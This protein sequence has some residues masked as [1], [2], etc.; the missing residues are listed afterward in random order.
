MPLIFYFSLILHFDGVR[1]TLFTDYLWLELG[2]ALIALPV[3]IR[4]GMYRAVIRYIDQEILVAA[5]NCAT[6]AVLLL[7]A[8]Y[9]IGPGKA[10]SPTPFLIYWAGSILYILASRFTARRLLNARRNVHRPV[11]VAIYGAG[12][13]GRLLA[14]AISPGNEYQTVLF[15][16]DNPQRVNTT[17]GGVHVYPARDLEQLAHTHDFTTVL[18]AMPSLTRQQQ[19]KVLDNLAQLSLIIKVTPPVSSIVTGKARVQ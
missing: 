1:S 6:L 19:R 14:H 9:Y 16:D 8:V 10:L 4:L 13:A 17:I 3:F 12:E 15:V 5:V 18:L 2:A 7:A 11:R